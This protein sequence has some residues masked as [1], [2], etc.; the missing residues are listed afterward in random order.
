MLRGLGSELAIALQPEPYLMA[1]QNQ[2]VG[3]LQAARP[4]FERTDIDAIL[5]A[6]R[7]VLESGHLILGEHT[8]RFERA[9]AS[10][11]GVTHA[12]AVSSCSAAIQIALRFFGV[13]QRE[14][15]LPTN[16]FPGV[17][18]AVLYEGGLPVLAD[19]DSGT[20]CMATE[21]ALKRITPRTAGIV[22]VHL[23]G[24]VYPDI[25]RVREVCRDRGLFLIEDV[26]HAHGASISSRKAGSLADAGCFSFYPTKIMTTGVGGMITTDNAKLAEYARSVRHHGQGRKREEFVQMGSDWCMTEINAILGRYQLER[27]DEMVDHRNQ[28]V[29]WYREGLSDADWLSIPRYPSHLRHAYYK[30]PT[31]VAEDVDRDLLRHTLENEFGVQNGTIYDPPCHLQPAFRD[32]LRLGPGAYPQAE[33]ML[34]R[35]LCPPIHAGIGREEVAAVIHAMGSVIDRCRRA[36]GTRRE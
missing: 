31:V 27:L 30:L 7:S 4:Q 18:S 21:D 24:L 25:D 29:Q 19:M 6:I 28:V 8:D 1:E 14:I 15:I 32:L 35:Q 22:V 36:P 17:V 33:R 11:I 9:F 3:R 23:G 16:N 26:A 2:R 13:D 34:A 10:Y 20:F 5:P 12:V